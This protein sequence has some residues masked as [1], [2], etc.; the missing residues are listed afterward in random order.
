MGGLFP[1]VLIANADE[2]DGGGGAGGIP[3]EGGD[4]DIPDREYSL[5]NAPFPGNME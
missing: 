1:S 3:E 4:G 5:Q 2:G